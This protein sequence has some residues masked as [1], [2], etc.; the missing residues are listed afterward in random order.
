MINKNFSES[1]QSFFITLNLN[2][3][4]EEITSAALYKALLSAFNFLIIE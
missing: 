3:H 4:K 1:L 2:K